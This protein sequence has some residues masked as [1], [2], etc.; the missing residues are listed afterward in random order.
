MTPKRELE[1]ELKERG[2]RLFKQGSKHAIYTNGYHRGM[3]S[4]GSKI[5]SRNMS[6]FVAD[7]NRNDRDL[8]LIAEFNKLVAY[9]RACGREL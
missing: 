1:R 4:S 3:M 9:L 6:N 8:R 2:Y 7:L 5:S